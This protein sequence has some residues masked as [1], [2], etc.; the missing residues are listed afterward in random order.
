[1]ALH[2]ETGD[3]D[4][5]QHLAHVELAEIELA[6]IDVGEGIERIIGRH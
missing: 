2:V 5:A 4:V 6:E 3:L 1:M